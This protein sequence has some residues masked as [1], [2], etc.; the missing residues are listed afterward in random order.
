MIS[1]HLR[2]IARP[3]LIYVSHII[4]NLIH[5]ISGTFFRAAEPR[6]RAKKKPPPATAAAALSSLG[7]G[8]LHRA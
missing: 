1:S 5:I 6:R 3:Q 2:F 7:P 8:R 4:L